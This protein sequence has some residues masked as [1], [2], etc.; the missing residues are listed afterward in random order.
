M[1]HISLW[2]VFVQSIFEILSELSPHNNKVVVLD[3]SFRVAQ[4]FNCFAKLLA[5][6]LQRPLQVNM[7]H[8]LQ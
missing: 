7:E 4:L 8:K 2:C 5:H 3:W 1:C 6:P